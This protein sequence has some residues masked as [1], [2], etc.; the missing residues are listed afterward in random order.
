MSCPAVIEVYAATGP[1]VVEV[2]TPGPQGPIGS[3]WITGSG[4]PGS[5]VGAVGDFYLRE[6]GDIYGAKT[7]GG[8]GSVQFTLT[9]SG[10]ASLSDDAPQPL[11]T[12]AAGTSI[13]ASRSDHRHAMPNA[14]QVGA[15]ANGT[16][17]AAVAAHAAAADPH[18]GYTTAQEAAAAAPVQSVAGRT[19]AVTL[20][21]ADVAG[22]GT[23][24]TTPATDYA[25]AAQGAKA[26][27]AVQPAG[28]AS[29]LAAKA[30]LVGGLVPPAQLPGFV[31]DVLE[32]ANV[33]AFPATGEAGKLYI[34]L[35]SNRTYRWSGSIY[36][37]INPSPGSTDAVPEGSVNLYFT[38]ARGEAAA[39][40]WWAASA[41]KTKLDGIA[42]GATANSSDAALIAR[43]NHTG[44]QPAI[45]ITGLAAVATS[46]AYADLSGR[47]SLGTAAEAATGDF[48]SGISTRTA[49][50][51]L[52]GPSS[53]SPAAPTFRSLA[54]NDLP[55]LT[56][57]ASGAGAVAATDSVLQAIQKLDGNDR[58][59]PTQSLAY[60]A[61]I[62]LDLATL[63]GT[64]QLLTLTGAVSFTAINLALGRWV[65]IFIEPGAANRTLT[66]PAGWVFL[67]NKPATQTANKSAVLT[68]KANG[69]S[70]ADIRAAWKESP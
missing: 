22:L 59:V 1:V 4:V 24:A 23:A 14:G 39:A 64:H 63:T 49:N 21:A 5:G 25:T 62:E 37:E 20:A 17:A 33:A 19:G 34:S 15:D 40:S 3:K 6:N 43:T 41:S 70:S 68:I 42:S 26:D 65:T 51:F 11:G 53:G 60:S 48:V 57:F 32:F 69:A 50:T 45:T 47:P 36:V 13:R 28:L 66:F 44:T 18:P 35:A 54:P 31:D 7:S 56:G 16:A 10:G 61:S 46:G 8:W 27:T 9:G 58:T 55:V 52:A 29:A 12:A 2:V 38:T 67:S 30:D